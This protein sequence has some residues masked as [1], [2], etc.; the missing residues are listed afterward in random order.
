MPS[1]LIWTYYANSIVSFTFHLVL[2]FGVFV[3]KL[4]PF[5]TQQQI[6]GFPLR[7]IRP[8]PYCGADVQALTY[9]YLAIEA[10]ILP[11]QS[12]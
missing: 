9:G 7:P 3:S 10:L 2:P 6:E 1:V 4:A 12:N 11:S 8:Y 5:Y